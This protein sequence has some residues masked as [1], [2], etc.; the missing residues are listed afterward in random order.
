MV[1]GT[2]PLDGTEPCTRAWRAAEIPAA[3]GTGN[4]RAMARIHSALA[5]GGT[6]DGVRLLSPAMLQRATEP[7]FE[8]TDALMN[9]P[10][11]FGMGYGLP[12][13]LIPFPNERTLFWGGWGGSLCVIDLEL[14]MS[15]AYA[16]NR[17]D[18]FALGDLRA[19]LLVLAAY[20][21]MAAG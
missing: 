8:G 16:M 21:A 10:A 19:V 4:A 3:N 12:S 14:R 7:Q 17:M 1:A 13:P 6:I 9:T 15:F 18:T 11:R 5:C 2:P 20:T